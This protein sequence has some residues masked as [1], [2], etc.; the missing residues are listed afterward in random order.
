MVREGE[1]DMESVVVEEGQN[2]RDGVIAELVDND[3]LD[4][5]KVDTLVKGVKEVLGELERELVLHRV[6]GTVVGIGEAEIEGVIEEEELGEGAREDEEVPQKEEVK[7]MKEEVLILALS[8][9]LGHIE[10]E[11]RDEGVTKVVGVKVK[12]GEGEEVATAEFATL[13]T[14]SPDEL[15]D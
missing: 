15:G 9:L 10:R 2:N 7:D 12:E 8:L 1:A 3:K 11:G 6:N 5:C 14:F 4:V 13:P